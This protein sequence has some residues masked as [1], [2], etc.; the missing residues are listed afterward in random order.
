MKA[1][2]SL[3]AEERALYWRNYSNRTGT[4]EFIAE[5]D[6]WVCWLLGR[7]FVTPQLGAECVFKDGTSLSK[8]FHTDQRPVGTHAI[9]PFVAELAPDAFDYCFNAASSFHHDNSL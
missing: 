6:F 4:P 3:P 2:A 9:M 5:K 1:F 7:I 8:V